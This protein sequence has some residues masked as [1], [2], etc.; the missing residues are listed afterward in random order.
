MVIFTAL[1]TVSHLNNFIVMP[2]YFCL[3]TVY[4]V[5]YFIK[6][7]VNLLNMEGG[8]QM[9]LIGGGGGGGGQKIKFFEWCVGGVRK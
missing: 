6:F 1:E 5:F 8:V 3:E 9:Q 2:V 7:I 4:S